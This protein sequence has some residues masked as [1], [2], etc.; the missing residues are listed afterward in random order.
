M[1]SLEQINIKLIV[2]A[3][4]SFHNYYSIG[5]ERQSHG[6]KN[7]QG[8]PDRHRGRYHQRRDLQREQAERCVQSDR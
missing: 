2:L 8:L 7:P 3:N 6:E 1:M 4:Y 5:Q